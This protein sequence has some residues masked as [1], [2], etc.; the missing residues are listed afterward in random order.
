MASFCVCVYIADSEPQFKPGILPVRPPVH[1][2]PWICICAYQNIL[3]ADVSED[4]NT[5]RCSQPHQPEG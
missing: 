4:F 3:Q 1:H 5:A 2:G